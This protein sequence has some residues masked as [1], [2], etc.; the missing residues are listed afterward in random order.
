MFSRALRFPL[1]VSPL[2][3]LTPRRGFSPSLCQT[4]KLYNWP[5]NFPPE[6][7]GDGSVVSYE[8]N[9]HKK[10]I[11]A[12]IQVIKDRQNMR[13][14]LKVRNE[15]EKKRASKSHQLAR[16]K[17]LSGEMKLTTEEIRNLLRL[18]DLSS[19]P[20]KREVLENR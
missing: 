4:K 3:S 19:L 17:V 13:E 10:K 16:R 12:Y 7:L 1:L 15:A 20:D 6:E 18:N 14:L 9:P 5:L 11:P 8:M 2:S